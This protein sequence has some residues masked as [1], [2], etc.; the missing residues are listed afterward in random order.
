MNDL[1]VVVGVVY[2]FLKRAR[3]HLLRDL[4]GFSL[5]AARA[6]PF[7]CGF[8]VQ[9]QHVSAVLYMFCVGDRPEIKVGDDC[10]VYNE[11]VEAFQGLQNMA[12]F[13]MC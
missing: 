10:G 11:T 1:A 12:S 13:C 8:D 6:S 9:F 2:C 3:L 7:L 4:D 5:P